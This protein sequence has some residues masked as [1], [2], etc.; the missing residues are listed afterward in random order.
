MIPL[1]H[2]KQNWAKLIC[3][4]REQKFR[5]QNALES[6]GDLDIRTCFVSRVR[7]KFGQ[8]LK[9]CMI[10]MLHRSKSLANWYKLLP[11]IWTA[12]IYLGA[13]LFSPTP[14]P[15]CHLLEGKSITWTVFVAQKSLRG[16]ELS[17]SMCKLCFRYST[18]FGQTETLQQPTKTQPVPSHNRIHNPQ[19][20]RLRPRNPSRSQDS[21]TAEWLTA[22]GSNTSQRFHEEQRSLE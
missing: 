18:S 20:P 13:L 5:I 14:I 21:T 3:S 19:S 9:S 6:R 8:T 11:Q 1:R 22:L 15:C 17:E 7:L 12:A 2:A 16:S 10:G 4:A